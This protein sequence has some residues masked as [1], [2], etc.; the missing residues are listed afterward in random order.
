M[1]R[2][3]Q[4]YC[5]KLDSGSVRQPDDR[6]KPKK[7]GGADRCCMIL[8][9]IITCP[10]CGHAAVE[11][12][13]SNVCQIFYDCRMRCPPKTK[14]WRLRVPFLRIGSV[15]ASAGQ[16]GRYA[17]VTPRPW[18]IEARATKRAVL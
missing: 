16:T 7:I 17:A 1:S 3:C 11:R 5:A 4:S 10:H 13:P 6:A 15:S 14:V 18:S 12:M 2:S 8:M 9:S